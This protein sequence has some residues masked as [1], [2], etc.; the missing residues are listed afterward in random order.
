MAIEQHESGASWQA[1]ELHA[2]LICI[3]SDRGHRSIDGGDGDFRQ[4]AQKLRD[5]PLAALPY[6]LARVTSDLLRALL[7]NRGQA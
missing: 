5:G 3:V 6:L 1:V 7:R 2:R 4:G